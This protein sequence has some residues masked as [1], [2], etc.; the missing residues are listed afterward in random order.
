MVEGIWQSDYSKDEKSEKAAARKVG[1]RRIWLHE[2][3]EI[4]K[5]G[6]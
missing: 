4:E 3:K 1:Q 5:K 2:I 6:T